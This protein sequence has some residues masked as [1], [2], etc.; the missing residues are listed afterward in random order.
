MI[1]QI[2]LSYLKIFYR[3]NHFS[4][5]IIH[6]VIASGHHYLTGFHITQWTRIYAHFSAQ[7]EQ[8]HQ[9]RYLEPPHQPTFF[10]AGS[11]RRLK[12]PASPNIT[13]SM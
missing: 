4:F 7:A 12:Q 9:L 5:M 11:L 3:F 10:R 8:D 1:L 13:I 6:K 2:T